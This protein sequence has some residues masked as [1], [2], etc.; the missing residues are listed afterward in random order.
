MTRSLAKEML[1]ALAASELSVAAF[2]RLHDIPPQ[3]V[4]YWRKQLGETGGAQESPVPPK[5]KRQRRFAPVIAK[6]D[7]PSEAPPNVAS[8]MQTLEAMLPGGRRVVVHGQWDASSMR[9]WL[10]AIGDGRC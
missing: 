1:A 9:S 2:C 7:R 3:R 8:P 6:A 10:E 4:W 5:P